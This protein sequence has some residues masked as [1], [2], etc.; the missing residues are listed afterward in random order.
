MMVRRS[1]RAAAA[2][3][4]AVIVL[5]LLTACDSTA[6]AAQPTAEATTAPAAAPSPSPSPSVKTLPPSELCTVLTTGV[7]EQLIADA[8]P[9]AR[10]SPDKGEAPD[11]CNYTAPDGTATLALTPATRAYDAELAAAHSLSADPASAGMRDVR[12]DPVSGL[13]TQ[14]FRETAYQI[15][16]GQHLTFVVWNTGTRSWVLTFATTADTPA[17]P[18][19][20]SDDKVVR[21]A[22]S[23]T[24]K[25]PAGR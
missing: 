15:Q 1:L 16:A 13:G 6:P 23:L 22:Q 2:G 25:L 19:A 9:V 11:V 24:A 17:T 8:R 18:S 20:A 10:V 21:M 4:I 14:G 12:V 7:A 5:G 3:S